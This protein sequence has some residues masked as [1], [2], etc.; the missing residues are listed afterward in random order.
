VEGI[1][2]S[3]CFRP[4]QEQDIDESENKKALLLS[5]QGFFFVDKRFEISN[6]SL[7]ADM[8]RIIKLAEVFQ[9]KVIH[10]VH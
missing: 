1:C 6:H 9:N 8:I 5:Q 4:L 7:I 10:L 2:E 3:F